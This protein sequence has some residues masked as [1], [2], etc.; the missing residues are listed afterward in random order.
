[1]HATSC[2][3]FGFTEHRAIHICTTHTNHNHNLPVVGWKGTTMHIEAI[4][5]TS[6]EFKI[7]FTKKI[8]PPYNTQARYLKYILQ[9]KQVHHTTILLYI[10]YKSHWLPH[11]YF[12]DGLCCAAFFPRCIWNW[13]PYI[14]WWKNTIRCTGSRISLVLIYIHQ[15][16]FPDDDAAARLNIHFGL[17]MRSKSA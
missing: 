15:L 11:M 1:M 16:Q 14:V 12:A 2:T 7:Y 4:Q 13:N 10:F 6:T 3:T 17:A 5:Y 8:I 9:K